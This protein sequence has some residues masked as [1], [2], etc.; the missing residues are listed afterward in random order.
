ME[1]KCACKGNNHFDFHSE[2]NCCVISK[3]YKDCHY[4]DSPQEQPKEEECKECLAHYTGEHTCPPWIKELVKRKEEGAKSFV[5]KLIKEG[6]F[7]PWLVEREKEVDFQAF[8]K[9]LEDF[10]E[11][12]KDKL[13]KST[14]LQPSDWKSRFEKE[15]YDIG[16]GANMGKVGQFIQEELSKKDEIIRGLE[17]ELRHCKTYHN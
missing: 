5:D 12:N 2:N 3:C 1:N 15:F 14:L 11:K 9:R 7:E 13:V 10:I 4:I 17:Q 8:R 16:F 6:F